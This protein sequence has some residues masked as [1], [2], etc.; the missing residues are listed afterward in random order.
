MRQAL[1]HFDQVGLGVEFQGAAVGQQGVEEGVV[2]PCLQT[3]EEHPVPHAEFGGPDRV[4]D[5]VG[6]DFKNPLGQAVDDLVPTVKKV[7][8]GLA[9]VAGR[10]IDLELFEGE[11]MKLT[12]DGQAAAAPDEFAAAV[13]SSGLPRLFLDVVDALD[14][15]QDRDGDLGRCLAKIGELTAHVGE[16]AT[17]IQAEPGSDGVIDDVAVGVDLS[18][19]GEGVGF[20]IVTEHFQQ[21]PGS[22]TGVPVEV[23][24]ARDRIAV[25]PQAALS[26]RTMAGGLIVDWG[27]VDLKFFGLEDFGADGAADGGEVP[28][29]GVGPGVECLPPDVDVV[30]SSEALGLAVVGKVVLVFVGDDLGGQGWS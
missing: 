26:N 11:A 15:K 7:A 14:E 27:L 20:G 12:G 21:A 5:S 9:D 18:G 29:G 16:T 4:L 25:D 23:T 19:V 8:E 13:W 28:G 3:A 10:T 30:S 2:G 22:A 6:V 17:V 1:D 24:G